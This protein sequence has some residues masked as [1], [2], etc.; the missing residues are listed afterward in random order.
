[1]VSPFVVCNQFG[2]SVKKSL[3]KAIIPLLRGKCYLR[4][5]FWAT[6]RWVIVVFGSIDSLLMAMGGVLMAMGGLWRVI[7]GLG[8]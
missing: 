5:I 6:I 7:D 1:M 2:K 8:I 4:Y 3:S